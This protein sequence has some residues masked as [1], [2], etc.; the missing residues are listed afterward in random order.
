MADKSS[1]PP[2]SFQNYD[3]ILY[4]YSNKFIEDLTT[5]MKSSDLV[6]VTCLD[7]DGTIIVTKSGKRFPANAD[8]W[9]F[10]KDKNKILEKLESASK[11]GIVIIITNQAGIKK[12]AELEESFKTKIENIAKN[13]KFEFAVFISKFNDKFHKPSPLMFRLVTK[14]LEKKCN[15]KINKELSVYVGDCYDASA[16]YADTD[17]KFALN[18]GIKFTPQETFFFDTPATYNKPK[19][20]SIEFLNSLGD[21]GVPT[22]D[23]QAVKILSLLKNLKNSFPQM[24]IF[25]GPPGSGKSHVSKLFESSGY[26]IVNQDTLGHLTKCIN[27][28]QMELTQSESV[29]IDRTNPD[30]DSRR[31]F[32]DIAKK[33]SAN[34][35]CILFDIPKYGCLI[36]NK[37]RERVNGIPQIPGIVYN[38]YYNKYQLPMMNEG[39]SDIYK[40]TT[41][42][43]FNEKQKKIFCEYH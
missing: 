2:I 28:T 20:E 14:L 4:G 42:P 24:I 29:V 25:V 21:L 10:N 19:N 40:I 12:S 3:T 37:Y 23:K 6:Y 34:I 5:K 43:E 31:K 38:L 22:T 15:F 7:L 39:Y 9:I 11:R 1:G 36:L 17:L 30:A 35:Y 26:R 13:F 41:H 18:C 32:I 16:H 33:F 8:D 27:V